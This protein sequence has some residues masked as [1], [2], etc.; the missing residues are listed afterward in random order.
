MAAF[1]CRF[2]GILPLAL[3][4]AL[5]GCVAP[6]SQVAELRTQNQNLAEQNRA[7]LTEIQNLR[8]HARGTEDQLR[9][10]EE[11]LAMLEER[12]GLGSEQ[13][14]GY[15]DER[16]LLRREFVDAVNGRL[17]ASPETSRRL[18]EFARRHPELKF[19]PR[20]GIAKL[21]SDIL[22][23]SGSVELKPGAETLLRDFVSWMS[24]TEAGDLRIMVV[25]HTDDRGVVRSPE[26]D[27]YA[28]N[29]D[30]STARSLEVAN[31][32]RGLGLE[33]RRIG[34]AGFGAHQP[35]VGNSSPR[36]R[37]KN[38]RVEVF[39]MAPDV[40]V[41]GWAETTPTLY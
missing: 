41:V 18:A 36:D 23:D 28:N 29:F 15:R 40:P 20:T 8:S 3:L 35:I 7:Q 19:D 31:R 6:L 27:R 5:G 10:A 21:D 34:V 9:R 4:I 22:F 11:D 12:L 38:R 14:A 25:G 16:E 13:L 26:N 1:S 33:P 32:L 30:L 2:V 39:V 24:Q 17:R 37:Y